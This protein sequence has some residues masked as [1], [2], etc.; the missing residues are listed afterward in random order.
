[1]I[2]VITGKPGHG[3][4]AYA[5]KWIRTRLAAGNTIYSNTKLNPEKMF[6]EKKFFKLF[7][8]KKGEQKIEGD[9]IK[10]ED[11]KT[12]KVLY[13]QNFSD[14][15]YFKDGIILVDEGLRYFNARRWEALSDRMQAR[16]TEHRKDKLDMIITVQDFSFIDKTIRSICETFINL[17]LI[18]G[19]SAFK[20]TFLPRIS[21]VS[22]ID[23]ATLARCENLGLNP[24]DPET[25]DKMNLEVQQSKFWIRPKIFDWYDTSAKMAESRPEQLVHTER[26]C[27]DC[28]H[29]KIQHA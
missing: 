25:I 18:I 2:Y 6:S 22:D 19:S 20:K 1:M 8:F 26:S 11:R 13:W 12:K 9:I 28:G 29:T 14:W 10:P 15:Q 27:P 17:E 5:V 7:G 3:K 24:Y 21:R 4:T 16:L 23:K